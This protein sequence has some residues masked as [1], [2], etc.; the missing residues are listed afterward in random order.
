[1]R[2]LV[3]VGTLKQ[4]VDYLE[5]QLKN[6]DD[7]ITE[8]RKARLELKWEGEAADTFNEIYDNYI[9]ELMDMERKILSYIK[10]LTSYYDKYGSEYNL[11]RKK[12]SNLINMEVSYDQN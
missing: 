8:L 1:M 2:Y 5:E 9:D 10:F 12:F 4:K 6:I 11:L 7:Q 3:K